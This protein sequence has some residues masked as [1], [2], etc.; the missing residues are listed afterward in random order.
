[1]YWTEFDSLYPHLP[2][3]QNNMSAVTFRCGREMRVADVEVVA[4][5]YMQW[6]DGGSMRP[7]P[8]TPVTR[9]DIGSS[10]LNF[11]DDIEDYDPATFLGE[12]LE[13]QKAGRIKGQLR[14]YIEEFLKS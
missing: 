2:E 10:R 8:G 6:K 14:D 9:R 11:P 1:M 3:E 13:L 12:L 4:F 7:L 5:W